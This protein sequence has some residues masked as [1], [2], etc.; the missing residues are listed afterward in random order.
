MFEQDLFYYTVNNYLMP[1]N[2]TRVGTIAALRAAG[3]LQAAS[4]GVL[5]IIK[6]GGWHFSY[7]GGPRM[8]REKMSA[9]SH[10]PDFWCQ[11]FLARDDHRMLNAIVSGEDV[12]RRPFPRAEW[13]ASNDPRLPHYYLQHPE[14]FRH[15][16]EDHFKEEL[17]CLSA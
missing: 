12:A 3:G 5:P 6:D 13:R 7:F 14:R 16:T 10:S 17:A 1:W 15:F 8:I 4:R 9:Y 11:E 2:G